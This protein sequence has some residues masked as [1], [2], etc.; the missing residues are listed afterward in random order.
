MIFHTLLAISEKN[1]FSFRRYCEKA[2]K[3]CNNRQRH[4]QTHTT[5]K[6][7]KCGICNRSFSTGTEVREHMLTHQAP[8]GKYFKCD[9]CN[10]AFSQSKSLKSH[11][12]AVH[13]NNG[14][15]DNMFPAALEEGTRDKLHEGAVSVHTVRDSA[16]QQSDEMQRGE[17]IDEC[18]IHSRSV[19]H[20]SEVGQSREAGQGAVVE[21]RAVVEQHEVMGQSGDN[22]V[23][24]SK[25]IRTSK[26]DEAGEQNNS[27]DFRLKK[28]RRES[29]KQQN[30]V[31]E[32]VENGGKAKKSKQIR[33]IRTRESV[34][35]GN[36]GMEVK[37]E[38]R[39]DGE[40]EE[41]NEHRNNIETRN[42]SH[43]AETSVDI[44][45]ASDGKRKSGSARNL[46]DTT[47]E[48]EASNEA[49]RK[50]L[51]GKPFICPKCDKGYASRSGLK[52]HYHKMHQNP[53]D[54]TAKQSTRQLYYCY[55]C[56][57]GFKTKR[58]FWLHDVK[59]HG[60]IESSSEN[61][62]SEQEK[63]CRAVTGTAGEGR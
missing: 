15:S 32:Q 7:F 19:Q 36:D 39:V 12:N 45:R 14:C 6:R 38:T 55:E 17:Q 50:I 21:Q 27:E 44:H 29:D 62:D 54:T 10:K 37:E 34:D 41:N 49:I 47:R 1:L 31:V 8:D 60:L 28:K 57:E 22:V 58:R 9:L 63:D 13:C 46:I 24:A 30:S 51:E 56:K 18:E 11:V 61:S 4:E 25:E 20:E 2:F 3:Q 5:E 35:E 52:H 33:N 59:V 43:T 48:T 53:T 23:H 40:T 16:G 42:N 26:C